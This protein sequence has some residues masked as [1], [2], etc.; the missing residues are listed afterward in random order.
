MFKRDGS[1]ALAWHNSPV[2]DRT[3][4]IHHNAADT[5]LIF[6]PTCYKGAGFYIH[7]LDGLRQTGYLWSLQS[8]RSLFVP[9]PHICLLRGEEAGQ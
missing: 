6:G 8:F 5:Q 4:L 2:V 3:G 1:V 9:C 7:K